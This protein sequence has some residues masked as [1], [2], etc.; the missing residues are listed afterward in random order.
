VT[1]EPLL[2]VDAVRVFF[3]G[4]LGD[5][6]LDHPEC[7][8]VAPD[9]SVWCGGERGQIFRIEPDGSRLEQ[10]ASTGGFCL[11]LAFS[12][13]GDLY[14]C[15]LKHAAVWRLAAGTD[16]PEMFAEGFR[17]PNYPAF[18]ADGRLYV[19]DSHG[20]HDPGP[21]IYRFDEDGSGGP[22]YD[23]SVDF[24]NGIAVSPDGGQLYVVETFGHGVF[25]VPIADD[26]SAGE[27]EHVATFPGVLPDGI[28]FAADGS[29]FVGCYEPST[30]LRVEPTGTVACVVLDPE[31]HAL[32]HPTNLAFRG[33]TLF[34]SNLGRWHV[35]AVE[36]DVEGVP[37][38]PRM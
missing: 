31:A 3:D 13:A 38:P 4:T 12:P 14:V 26:G 32:C 8:A 37:L 27:R 15:D 22:W 30:V 25:R 33:T 11:G 35:A 2:P 29:L 23:A 20:F 6:Q 19:S 18:D 16:K 7:V 17:V 34:L 28:A 5:P 1:L 10:V 36:L 9:G 21:G 24:A